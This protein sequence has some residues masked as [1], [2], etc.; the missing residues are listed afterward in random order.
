MSKKILLD[1][2]GVF[3]R[4]VE[5]IL[6]QSGCPLKPEEIND[7]QMFEMMTP[8]VQERAFDIMTK[9]KFWREMSLY[10]FAK[11]MVK[12]FQKVGDVFFLTAPYARNPQGWL[13]KEWG[14]ARQQWLQEHFGFTFDK[15]IMSYSK[16]VVQGDILIDDRMKN[17]EEWK[18]E[19]PDG[20]AFLVEKPYSQMF[21][22]PNRIR[23]TEKGWEFK[24]EG[25]YD[26]IFYH[27]GLLK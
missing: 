25:K 26:W 23:I 17:I 2:D 21:A 12:E 8:D 18:K 13:C 4:F 5:D 3:A 11:E 14:W 15:I 22:W 9:E 10:P 27:E 1:V 19:N 7:W 16:G 20:K 24:E 6:D